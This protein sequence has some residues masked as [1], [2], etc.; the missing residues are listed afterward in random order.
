MHVWTPGQRRPQPPQWFSSV[1]MSRQPLL[2]QAWSPGQQSSLFVTQRLAL[3]GHACRPPGQPQEVPLHTRSPGQRL[4]QRPQWSRLLLTRVQVPLHTRLGATQRQTRP[5]QA[6][7]PVQALPQ[8]PQFPKF[9]SRLTQ[10]WPHLVSPAA[11]LA[12]HLPRLH[13]CV[14]G[15]IMPHEPQFRESL[16]RSV[17]PMAQRTCPWAQTTWHWPFMQ[18]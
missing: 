2:H 18:I 11:Q 5:T 7:A 15:H 9:E 1:L 3:F 8:N 6:W 4:P 17:Q 16:D 13:T 12:A 10:D 14:C